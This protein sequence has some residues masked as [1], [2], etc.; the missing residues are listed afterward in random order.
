MLKGINRFLLFI[1]FGFFLYCI[2]SAVI[3][4][5]R[6]SVISAK[7]GE[8]LDGL[9][10]NI[11][12]DLLFFGFVGAAGIFAQFYSDRGDILRERLRRVFLSKKVNFSL[13]EYFESVVISNC[14]FAEEAIHDVTIMEFNQQL[15]A[16]RA[17]FKNTY[18][19]RNALGDVHYDD[20]ISVEVAPD[21]IS[22][23]VKPLAVILY[24][25]L[26]DQRGTVTN[27]AVPGVEV[28]VDGYRQ[29]VRMRLEP[30]GIAKFELAWWSWVALN[31]N[32]GFSVKR[33]AERFVVRVQNRSSV[34]ARLAL[35]KTGNDFELRTGEERQIADLAKLAPRTR[36]EFFWK[37]P[38]SVGL[39][40]EGIDIAEMA[41]H[42]ILE[43]DNK[44][45]EKPKL[46]L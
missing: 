10:T 45:G 37:S 20:E 43:F 14:V 34:I 16:Y 15:G 28:G 35:D 36:V 32:S 29:T 41:I 39:I 22:D 23:D 18:L 40:N 38:K 4:A 24:L 25:R 44:F 6:W 31:G 1:I 8:F 46:G 12:A 13:I 17:D 26:T 5:A 3:I 11:V 21:L 30:D 19:L 42:P 7:L 33:F 27:F 2:A 9:T